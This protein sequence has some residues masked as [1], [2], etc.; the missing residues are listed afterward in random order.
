MGPG[1]RMQD[2]NRDRTR[3]TMTISSY[4]K[5]QRASSLPRPSGSGDRAHG[6]KAAERI[7]RPLAGQH[8][9]WAWLR[10]GQPCGRWRRKTA[11]GGLVRVMQEPFLGP[12]RSLPFFAHNLVPKQ[13]PFA[14]SGKSVRLG[15]GVNFFFFFEGGARGWLTTGL[16][17]H[18]W[19]P[20]LMQPAQA[21]EGEV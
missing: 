11:A 14:R 7:W 12:V 5:R 15:P 8:Q 16:F 9:R 17:V 6:E 4:T 18:V 1:C 10:A 3:R 20:L 2:G 13:Q 21:G 19:T